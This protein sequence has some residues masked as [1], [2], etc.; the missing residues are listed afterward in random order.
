MVQVAVESTFID[1]LIIG[2]G[3]LVI[4]LVVF[5]G[6]WAYQNHVTPK[7]A[8]ETKK[9]KQKKWPLI[10]TV[11]LSHFADL[12]AVSEI[13]A[14]RIMET[15]PIGKGLKKYSLRFQLPQKNKVDGLEVADGKDEDLTREVLQCVL[16][17]NAEKVMLRDTRSPLFI[18]VQDKTIAAGIKGIGALT[19]IN[20]LEK[21][22]SVKEQVNKLAETSG[23]EELG[24]VCQSFLEKITLVDFD[25]IR[26]HFTLSWDQGIDEATRQY[27]EQIGNKKAGKGKDDFRMMCLYAGFMLIGAACLIA[28]LWLVMG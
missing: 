11:G 9:A 18:A 7:E 4:M 21:L 24:K 6:V 12:F 22:C 27:D 19:F 5:F 17:L 2:V 16:N 20:K 28:V 23:F 3:A 25:A 1:G 15:T 26:T 14:G 10:L 8:R 13:I